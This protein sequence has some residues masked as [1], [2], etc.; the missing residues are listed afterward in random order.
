MGALVCQTGRCGHGPGGVGTSGQRRGGWDRVAK[1]PG[2]AARGQRGGSGVG[3]SAPATGSMCGC[4]LLSVHRVQPTLV[5]RP[6]PVPSA[7][8]QR[9]CRAHAPRALPVPEVSRCPVLQHRWQSLSVLQIRQHSSAFISGCHVLPPP[10]PSAPCHPSLHPSCTPCPALGSQGLQCQRALRCH[11]G[12]SSSPL[13]SPL[14]GRS[15]PLCRVPGVG[16]GTQ[17]G[18]GD[19]LL[20]SPPRPPPVQLWAQVSPWHSPHM[21]QQLP[22]VPEAELGAAVGTGAVP[23][24]PQWP[25]TPRRV[26]A[27]L[28][29]SL[30]APERCHS[31]ACR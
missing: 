13:L 28:P 24:V 8:P 18:W 9:P 27:T 26:S 1:V 15:L 21:G 23:S 16:V 6:C 12:H 19:P 30:G 11:P 29:W 31:R 22:R 14:P 2:A 4:R 5:P 10:S 17:S 3:G 20:L 7:A 25:G